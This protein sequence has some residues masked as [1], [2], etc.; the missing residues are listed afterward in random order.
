ML[1]T[2]SPADDGKGAVAEIT[3]SMV[4]DDCQM[5]VVEGG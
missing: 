5:T 2:L 4:P 3:G 1:V